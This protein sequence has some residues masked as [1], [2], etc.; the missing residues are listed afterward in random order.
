MQYINCD[1]IKIELANY[2][3]KT[4]SFNISETKHVTKNLTTDAIT[5]M[6]CMDKSN[7][8]YFA[9]SLLLRRAIFLFTGLILFSAVNVGYAERVQKM[10]WMIRV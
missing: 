10:Q 2:I 8:K 4:R 9:K 5:S 1:D 6:V 3:Y 7:K